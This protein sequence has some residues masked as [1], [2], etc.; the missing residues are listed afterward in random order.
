MKHPPT[1]P[2][3]KELKF[4]SVNEVAEILRLAPSTVYHLVHT[5]K[6]GFRKHGRRLVFTESNLLAF[7]SANIYNPFDATQ[8]CD[9]K[10]LR[11]KTSG[12]SLKT[13]QGTLESHQIQKEISDD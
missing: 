9:M 5:R 13:R 2:T 12:S 6:I 1:S 10:S 4:Y 8:H 11:H 7:S 3:S